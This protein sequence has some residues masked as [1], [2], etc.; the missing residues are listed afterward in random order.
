MLAA[1]PKAR[2]TRT[3]YN[4][5][6]FNPSAGEI[7]DI[8]MRAFPDAELTTEVDQKRQGIVDSW[9]EDVDDSAARADWGHSPQYGF[10]SAFDDYLIPTIRR[11]YAPGRSQEP[12]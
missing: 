3:V 1:A 12:A 7:R 4:I 5:A 9:P 11:R 6:S 2:L 8:V 10:E